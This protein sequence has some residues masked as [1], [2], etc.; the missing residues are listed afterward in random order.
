M[1]QSLL[2]LILFPYAVCA[3]MGC[4]FSEF[5]MWNFFGGDVL[6]IMIALVFFWGIAF[7]STYV[8]MYG[9][10]SGKRRSRRVLK[11]LILVKVLKIP[12]Y[13]A[14]L[15]IGTVLIPVPQVLLN[16]VV[17]A[18]MSLILDA[19]ACVYAIFRHFQHNNIST[20]RCV[21]SMVCQF[22]FVADIISLIPMYRNAKRKRRHRRRGE[23]YTVKKISGDYAYIAD[24]EEKESLVSLDLLPDDV[25]EGDKLYYEDKEYVLAE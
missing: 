21:W 5:V 6:N 19:I 20:E 7:V 24:N 17:L 12:A 11:E 22:V 14:M 18:Y 16:F 8:Y 25:A 4:L 3:G 15:F 13:I 23:K 2:L 10:K 9:I 1:K